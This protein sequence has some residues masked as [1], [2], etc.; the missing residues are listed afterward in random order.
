MDLFELICQI[1]NVKLQITLAVWGYDR[2]Y[3]AS[4]IYVAA[5]GV[6]MGRSCVSLLTHRQPINIFRPSRIVEMVFGFGSLCISKV[7]LVCAILRCGGVSLDYIYI[8]MI[9]IL[10]LGNLYSKINMANR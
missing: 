7:C 8:F 10:M 1:R 2:G 9:N 6:T 5:A 4:A 3:L